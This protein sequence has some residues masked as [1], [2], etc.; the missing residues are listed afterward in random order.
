MLL[1]N[2]RK[3]SNLNFKFQQNRS[4]NEEFTIFDERGD[5]VGQE[6]LIS[7]LKKMS[8]GICQLNIHIKFQQDRII[9]ED[10]RSGKLKSREKTQYLSS[11]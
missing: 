8:S 3:I 7:K 9:N 1:V 6:T 4:I 5:P 2:I 10:N 11:F